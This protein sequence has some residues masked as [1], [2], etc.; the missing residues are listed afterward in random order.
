[1]GKGDKRTLRGKI[2]KRS[3]GK[4]PPHH[5]KKQAAP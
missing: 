1:M 3:Y 4:T 5:P 2:F